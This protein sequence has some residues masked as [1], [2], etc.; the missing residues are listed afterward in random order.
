MRTSTIYLI[1]AAAI[2]LS[3]L[4]V[5]ALWGDM[6]DSGQAHHGGQSMSAQEFQGQ[7]LAQQALYGLPDGSLRPP[8]GTQVYVLAQ[9]YAF[10]PYTL[11]LQAGQHYYF[12]FFSSDVVHGAAL[13]NSGGGSLNAVILPGV[14]T[15]L[16]VRASGDLELR[17]NEYCGLAHHLM[18]GRI[19]VEE[20]QEPTPPNPEDKPPETE[21]HPQSEGHP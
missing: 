14:T 7:L 11:R 18:Q 19:I 4:L 15:E 5:I 1:V 20:G 10:L 12:V 9:Q 21:E 16:S 17:C 8:P 13:V 6:A 2:S 3:V